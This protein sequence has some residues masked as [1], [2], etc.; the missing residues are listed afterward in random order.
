MGIN[1]KR[2]TIIK[3]GVA[4]GG[5]ALTGFP[6]LHAL[7]AGDKFKGKTIRLLTWADDTG[8]AVLENI[9]KTFEAKTGA[10]VIADRVSATS[11]MIAKIKAAGDRPMYDILTVA[12]VAATTLG[13]A[14]LLEKPDL[15]LIPNLQNVDPRFRLSPDGHGVGY[16]LWTGGMIYN[17]QT[18]KEAPTSYAEMWDEKYKGRVF[19]PPS[20][21]TDAIDTIVAA[22]KI[23]GGS[24][25]EPQSG[26]EKLKK[27]KDSVLTFGE[28][29]TQIA[30]LIRSNQLDIGAVYPPALLAKQIKDP[31]FN[32]GSTYNLKEGFF[33]D[34]M[35]TLIPKA[36]PGQSEVINAFINHSLDPE[37]QGVMAE[38]V[39]NGPINNK[40]IMS[41]YAKNSPDIIKPDQL[42]DMAIIHDKALFAKV[43]QDLIKG[44]TRALM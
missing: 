31:A 44:Y 32:I 5:A 20:N 19:L 30:E 43:R 14:G 39:L 17:K 9:A 34:L 6:A 37:V 25:A 21:W 13:E 8:L 16:L 35:Y 41:D 2:R 3:T 27:L 29:P 33:A 22:A 38:A 11:D 24:M 4:L 12:G 40:A 28:N 15:N 42:T 23:D 36:H 7:G 1:K 18:F 10:K 26:F